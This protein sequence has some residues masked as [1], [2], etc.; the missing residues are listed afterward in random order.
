MACT[1]RRRRLTSSTD[2]APVRRFGQTRPVTRDL[3]GLFS[4]ALGGDTSRVSTGASDRRLHAEDMTFHPAA[5]PDAVVYPL[6]TDEVA[7]VL[8]L[9]NE[10]RIPVTPFGVGSSLEGHIIPTAGGITVDLSRM[11]RILSVTPVTSARRSRPA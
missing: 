3:I 4:P 9:A 1:V 10:H 8:A 6:T 2:V 5:D 11:N 7:G